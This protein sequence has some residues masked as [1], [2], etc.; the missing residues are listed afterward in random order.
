M[1]VNP[2]NKRLQ[3]GA[4]HPS[5]LRPCGFQARPKHNVTGISN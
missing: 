1:R 5:L 2:H 3:D 4:L